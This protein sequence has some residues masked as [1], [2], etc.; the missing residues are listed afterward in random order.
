MEKSQSWIIIEN[1]MTQHDLDLSLCRTTGVKR[2]KKLNLVIDMTPMVD[3]GFLLVAFFILTTQLSQPAVAKLYMP[4]DGAFTNVPGSRSLSILIGGGTNL[5]YYFGTEEEAMEQ[6]KITQTAYSENA[7]GNVIRQKQ[8]SLGEAKDSMIVLI[9]A[10]R[11]AAYKNLVDILD[12]M[13]IN[14]VKRY[15][16]VNISTHE[17]TF[18]EHR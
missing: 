4:H 17:K 2:M 16:I 6:N 12:E 7:I 9:K 8:I 13:T 5:F 10:G 15:S 11:D 1:I 3:L 18:L 14:N